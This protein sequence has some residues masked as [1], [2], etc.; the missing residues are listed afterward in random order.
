MLEH[1][2]E[3]AERDQDVA[4]A[5]A[6]RDVTAF[7]VADYRLGHATA[8]LTAAVAPELV[9][10]ITGGAP[11]G[12]PPPRDAF[13]G[14]YGDDLH[15]LIRL[16]AATIGADRPA[17][18]LYS[19]FSHLSTPEARNAIVAGLSPEIASTLEGLVDDLRAMDP[20]AAVAA[21]HRRLIEFVEQAVGQHLD[22]AAGAAAGDTAQVEELVAQARP[23]LCELAA[24]LSTTIAP[25]VAALVGPVESACDTG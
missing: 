21:D 3:L 18:A 25:A 16:V 20:P 24:S 17:N 10:A 8:L 7:D 5:V 22:L 12:S 13:L 23:R 2:A 9:G 15:A 4:A 14:T 19:D 11:A 6:A 1:L